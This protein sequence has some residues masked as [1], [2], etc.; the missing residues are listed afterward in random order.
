MFGF[1]NQASSASGLLEWLVFRTVS[2][3]TRVLG[4]CFHLARTKAL[5]ILPGRNRVH[6]QSRLGLKSSRQ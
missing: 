3:F 4:S 1:V 5:M 6:L 2:V